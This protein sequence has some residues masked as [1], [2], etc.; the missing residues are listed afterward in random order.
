MCAPTSEPFS[1]TQTP[2][3]RLRCA[4]S[5]FSRIAAARPAGPAPTIDYVVLHR[6]AFGHREFLCSVRLSEAPILYADVAPATACRVKACENVPGASDATAHRGLE[7]GRIVARRVIAGEIEVRERRARAADAGRRACRNG[8]ALFRNHAIHTG[9]GRPPTTAVSSSM[10]P[11][12]ELV[13][14]K[15]LMCADAADHGADQAAL[16]AQRF[17]IENPVYGS[18]RESEHR[19]G[20]AQPI[21]GYCSQTEWIG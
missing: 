7:G 21:P 4:A 18:A 12:A 14:R 15:V 16:P 8:R 19:R 6:F 11:Q 10:N 5:C 13:L 9:S 3:S 20:Q 1:I 17:A 2:I